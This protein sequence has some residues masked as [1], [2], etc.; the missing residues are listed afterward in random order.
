M[1]RTPRVRGARAMSF[2]LFAIAVVA[3]CGS[4]EDDGPKAATVGSSGTGG[5]GAGSLCPLIGTALA[6]GSA[7]IDRGDMAFAADPACQ[8]V[9]MFFGDAAVPIMCGPAPSE[10]LEDVYVYD[11]P[12]STWSS[13]A[14]QGGAPLSRARGRAVWDETLGRAV[15]FGGRW[16][17]GTTGAYEYPN[18]VWAFD[19]T[20]ASWEQLAAATSPTACGSALGVPCG[21][22]N[23]GLVADPV[24][25]RVIIHA[26]GTLDANGTTYLLDDETWAFDLGA[27][28][29][30]R[31]G[32]AGAPPARLFHAMALDRTGGRLVVFGGAGTNA[33][34]FL[35]DGWL[36]D[37]AADSWSQIMGPAPE[38]RLRAEMVYDAVRNRMVLFAGHDDTSLGNNN[39]VWTLDLASIAW[40]RQPGGDTFNQPADGFCDFPADFATVDPERPE[41]RAAHLFDV[42]GD[43]A[44]MYGG[45]TDCG[46]ARD[47]WHLDLA[48]LAWT[49]INESPLGMTCHRSG[50]LQCD[51][52]AARLCI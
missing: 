26:G 43:V 23:M 21:R 13:I 31:L 45:R 40:T 49:Q 5:S 36:L 28:S 34:T 51:D 18:D 10:F 44:V 3:A 25:D 27:R 6:E 30:S 7:P 24:R 50:S 32:V 20:A 11:V 42:V 52:P 4:S 48:T 2:F 41:R 33:A 1:R 22:M 16:R 17:M 46:V 12:T 47:T 38:R 14:V 35:Q 29:W 8:R 19:P 37:I 9:F 39:D 15:L